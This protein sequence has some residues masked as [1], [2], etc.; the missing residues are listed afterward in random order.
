MKVGLRCLPGAPRSGR[1]FLL[2]SA[3]H[4]DCG[5]LDLEGTRCNAYEYGTLSVPS[6]ARRRVA[7]CHSNL[8]PAPVLPAIAARIAARM[9][10][11]EVAAGKKQLEHAAATAVLP[12]P[13]RNCKRFAEDYRRSP[14]EARSRKTANAETRK[15]QSGNRSGCSAQ[16]A[17]RAQARRNSNAPITFVHKKR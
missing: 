15:L 11:V 6:E 4:V 3:F 13:R 7:H 1:W 5:R 16:A 14:R 10:R 12:T 2:V 17:Q 9:V 8:K